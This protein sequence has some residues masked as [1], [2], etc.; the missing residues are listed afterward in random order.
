MG[1]DA[2]LSGGW[3]L[4]LA[5][6]EG[7]L[8]EGGWQRTQNPRC[9]AS[10]ARRSWG[11]GPRAGM[12]V[13][14]HGREGGNVGSDLGAPR[15]RR[16]SG[17]RRAVSGACLLHALRLGPCWAVGQGLGRSGLVGRLGWGRT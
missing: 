10:G 16:C 6:L 5:F 12:G 9:L 13:A 3:W 7:G 11:R 14:G 1:Q 8:Q 4:C 17:S 2:L 15:P